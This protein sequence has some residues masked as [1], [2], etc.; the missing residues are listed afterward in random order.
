[1]ST[2]AILDSNHVAYMDGTGSGC[3]TV[4]H[5][6]ERG[7]ARVTLMF[8]SFDSLPRIVRLFCT[9]SVIEYTDR[10]FQPMLERMGVVNRT[11]V[12]A[13][14][15]L[16]VWQCQ[17]SCGMSV[18]LIGEANCDR[19]EEMEEARGGK[20]NGKPDGKTM[21]KDEERHIYYDGQFRDRLS[22]NKWAD[23]MQKQGKLKNY[24][25]KNNRTSM[26]GLPGLKIARKSSGQWMWL[27]DIRTLLLRAAS[28]SAGIL[29]GLF[30]GTTIFLTMHK[31]NFIC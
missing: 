14:I 6:Y 5:C 15:C 1:M 19:N 7:N 17:T 21:T 12:R 24:H 22:L 28:E 13:V 16:E 10:R 25:T 2:F 9:G 3:E 30:L 29:L 31:L 11:G 20:T 8:C 4:S 23:G 26:D 27:E 18:P